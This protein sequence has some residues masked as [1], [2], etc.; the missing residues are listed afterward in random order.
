LTL[1]LFTRLLLADLFV[2]G[3]GGAKYDEMTDAL[4]ARLF[5]APPPPY[6]TV[7]ATVWLP[8]GSPQRALCTQCADVGQLQQRLWQLRHNPQ[9]FVDAPAENVE[10]L[11]EEKRA[12]IADSPASERSAR[13]RRYLRLR[14]INAALSAQLVNLQNELADSLAAARQWQ[15]TRRVLQSREFSWVL[16]PEE[17]LRSFFETT[18]PG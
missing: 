6:L 11:I 8:F 3:L 15:Q 2:H 13:R 18:F 14:E 4:A 16:F 1:T 7:S 5:G 9:R 12:L 17:T 10:R